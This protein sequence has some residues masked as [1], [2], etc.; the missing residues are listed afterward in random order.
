MTWI[1]YNLS[2][3]PDK[4]Q[5][6]RLSE[7]LET[8]MNLWN[9]LADEACSFFFNNNKIP[10]AYDLNRHIA[11]VKKEHPELGRV[12]SG[13]LQNVSSRVNRSV[14]CSLRKIGENGEVVLP[15]E[16]TLDNYHSF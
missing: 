11:H 13:V 12:C 6:R 14:T 1:T 10:S 7:T 3:R 9:R 8:C 5:Q 4:M 15:R 2:L 16:R